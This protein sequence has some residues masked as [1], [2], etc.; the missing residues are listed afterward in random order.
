MYRSIAQAI[1]RRLLVITLLLV[2]QMFTNPWAI[3][4]QMDDMGVFAEKSVGCRDR[5]DL[6]DYYEAQLDG[7]RAKSGRFISSGKCVELA[8][9][10]YIPLR[11]GFAT[12]AV[13]IK[14]NGEQVVIWALTQALVASPP[15]AR[16]SHFNF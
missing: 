3:A 4:Q 2:G 13:Q 12:S 11:T 15:P 9:R 6:V 14:I 5:G 8:G 7:N 1:R 16:E 10:S